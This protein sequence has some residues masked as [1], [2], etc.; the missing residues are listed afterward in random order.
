MSPA[1]E[2][3]EVVGPMVLVL[4]TILS[5]QYRSLFVMINPRSPTFESNVGKEKKKRTFS[6]FNLE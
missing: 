5:V 2:E 3:A 4:V 1:D 6:L